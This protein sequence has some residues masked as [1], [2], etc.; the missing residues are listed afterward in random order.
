MVLAF[1]QIRVSVILRFDEVFEDITVT[2]ARVAGR[3]PLIE[4]VFVASYI[5]HVVEDT[6]AAEDL[7]P[8]KNCIKSSAN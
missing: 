4:V 3:L 2:P 8:V 7:E 5:D 6:G 1:R